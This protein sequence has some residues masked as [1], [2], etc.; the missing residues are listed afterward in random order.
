MMDSRN[1]TLLTELNCRPPNTKTLQNVLQGSVLA[2]VNVGPVKIS[3][4]FL[5]NAD[6]Y[7]QEDIK[8]LREAVQDFV[9]LCGRAVELNAK[10]IKDD[11]IPFQQ[12]LEQ[13]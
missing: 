6:K 11:Q 3:E 13:G 10:L 2:R 12:N 8:R 9:I 5:G 4:V 7:P 1:T